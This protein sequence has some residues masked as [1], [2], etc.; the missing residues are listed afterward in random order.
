MNS[1][2]HPSLIP[3]DRVFFC[4]FGHVASRTIFWRR[5]VL[6]NALVSVDVTEHCVCS[7]AGSSGQVGHRAASAKNAR[8]SSQA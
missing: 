2:R 6:S 7:G 8:Y 5:G 4:S 1:V 3:P